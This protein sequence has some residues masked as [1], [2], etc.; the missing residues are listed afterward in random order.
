MKPLDTAH[1]ELR[2][3]AEINVTPFIDVV[4]VLLV[5]FMVAAPLALAEVPLKLPGSEARSAVLP[6]E[7]VVL[8]LTLDGRLFIDTEEIAQETLP[9]RLASLLA[10]D[11]ERVFHVRADEGVPYGEVLALLGR[12]GSGGAGRLS[13]LSQPRPR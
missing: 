2:P 3:V 11:P 5:V 4:L 8:S 9:A 7:P 10:A 6:A 12:L 13:L 1:G